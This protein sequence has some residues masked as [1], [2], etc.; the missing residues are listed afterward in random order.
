MNYTTLFLDRDGVINQKPPDGEYIKSLDEFH[1]L[2]GVLQAMDILDGLFKHIIVVTNQRG[3][4]REIVTLQTIMV[5]HGFL[6]ITIPA[7]DAI[8]Y[9]PHEKDSC[10]CRKPLPGLAYAAK[11]QFP[12]ISFSR[13]IV[14]GDSVSDMEFSKNIGAGFYMLDHGWSLLDFARLVEGVA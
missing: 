7:I 13:S 8:Y 6:G 4:A 10:Q 2:P 5:I 14:V 3:V 12:D 9:C 11:K 1:I